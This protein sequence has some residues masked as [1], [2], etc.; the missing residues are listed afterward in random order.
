[1]RIYRI[2]FRGGRRLPAFVFDCVFLTAASF[3]GVYL[4]VRPYYHNRTAAVLLS[5]VITSLAVLVFFSV[6]SILFERH[7][8]KMRRSA[9]DEIVDLKLRTD[10]ARERLLS[11]SDSSVFVSSSVDA[12]TA[13]EIKTAYL[14]CARPVKFVAFAEPTDAAK[15]LISALSDITVVSPREFLGSAVTTS[16]DVEESEIDALLIR[17]YGKSI[18]PPK[19][20]KELFVLSRERAMKYVLLGTALMLLSFFMR[21]ALYYRTV[22]SIVLGI[23]AAVFAK[24]AH[25]KRIKEKAAQ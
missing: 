14:T 6:R 16:I 4:A 23:G 21:Y 9:R 17:K 1:M 15:K 8:G 10:P 3:S 12:P 24:D 11:S 13:D 25:M 7:I 2:D 5:F 18:A 22:A 19:I 20:R